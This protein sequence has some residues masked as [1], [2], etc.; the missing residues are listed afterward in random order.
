MGSLRKSFV[1]LC[2]ARVRHH[3]RF[4]HADVVLGFDGSYSGDAAAIVAVET[5]EMPH[6]DVVRLWEPER[7]NRE[8]SVAL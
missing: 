3:A 4:D 1:D 8:G 2:G 6:V 7:L 5:G